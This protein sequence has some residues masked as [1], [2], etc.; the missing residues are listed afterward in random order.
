MT[1]RTDAS[2]PLRGLLVLIHPTTGDVFAAHPGDG[3]LAYA[4]ILEGYE[5]IG[6]QGQAAAARVREVAVAQATEEEADIA[7]EAANK[8]V[9]R[10]AHFAQLTADRS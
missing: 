2:P 1:I 9:R 4:L 8:I 3:N 7:I 10:R 6:P 5:P